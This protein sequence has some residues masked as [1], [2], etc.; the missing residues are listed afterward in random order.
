MCAAILNYTK[1][2]D[3]SFQTQNMA[4]RL[5]FK[6]PKHIGYNKKISLHICL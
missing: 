3:P 5:V 2:G 1:D 6:L 4:K